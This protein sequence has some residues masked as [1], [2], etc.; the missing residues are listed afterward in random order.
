MTTT[1]ASSREEF[2][3]MLS[4]ISEQLVDV[5][6]MENALLRDQKYSALP[7]LQDE[8]SRLSAAYENQIRILSQDPTIMMGIPADQKNHLASIAKRFD[9]A[10]H[11]NLIL[12]Q[13]ATNINT[14]ILEAIRDAA[15]EQTQ[16]K[17]GYGPAAPTGR[18]NDQAISITLDKRL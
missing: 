7:Q 11:E 12:L 3:V 6:A 2:I 5:I 15:I 17:K 16:T 18:R 4:S 10:A 1:Q 13:S 14:R 9:A 8:K